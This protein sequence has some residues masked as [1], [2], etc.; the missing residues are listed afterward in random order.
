M[1]IYVLENVSEV[2]G[3]YL[4]DERYVLGVFSSYEL[5]EEYY[6]KKFYKEDEIDITEY[7]LDKE[8]LE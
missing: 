4:P 7:E 8:E 5:T 2:D 6:K 3:G 1:K